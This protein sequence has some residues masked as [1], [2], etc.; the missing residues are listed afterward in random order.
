MLGSFLVWQSRRLLRIVGWL[1][2]AGMGLALAVALFHIGVF[3]PLRTSVA[4]M[5]DE[6]MHL[7]E[8]IATRRV[9]ES[10]QDTAAQLAEFY[11]FFPE[12]KV[13][14]LVLKRIYA[15]A[16]QENLVLEHGEYQLVP[17]QEDRLL[18]Y[19]LTLPIKGPYTRL[20]SFIARVL[21]DNPSLALEGVSFSRQ[22]AMEIGVNAQVKMTLFLRAE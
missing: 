8:R 19:N 4:D 18:R 5:R 2:V 10:N 7:R 20:R 17:A 13:M 16:D 12:D 11:Q 3:V 22:T 15:A 21:H 9:V 1:G 14:T 6:T